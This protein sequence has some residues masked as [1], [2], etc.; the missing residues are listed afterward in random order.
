MVSMWP[1]PTY[2]NEA[3]QSKSG[4]L[5]PSFFLPVIRVDA[6]YYCRIDWKILLLTDPES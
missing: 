6:V 5:S 4:S 2:A 1:Q 3:V